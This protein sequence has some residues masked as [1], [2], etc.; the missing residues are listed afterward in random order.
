MGSISGVCAGSKRVVV[1]RIAR[2]VA[3]TLCAAI[4]LANFALA[5]SDGLVIAMPNWPSGQA[6]ANILK[7]AIAEKFGLAAEIRELGA[8]NAFAG[9]EAGT[10]DIYPEVWRPNLDSIV[11]K[12]VSQKKL[13]ILGHHRVDAWQGLCATPAAAK[14][15][16]AISDLGDPVKTAPLDTDGDGK[17]ELWIGAATWLSAGIE[18]VRANSYGYAANLTLVEAEEQVA[19]A[20]VDAAVATERPMVFA[21]YSPH[22]VFDL[23]A[24]TRLAEPP[25]DPGHWA[26]VPADDPLWISKSKAAVAWPTAYFNLAYASS[27]AKQRPEIA[28]FLENV[29][30]SPEEV[31]QMSYALEV[32]RQSASDFAEAWVKTNQ[33][34]VDGWAKP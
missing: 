3:V 10:V 8:L 13:V 11:D 31:T 23:H 26:I 1:T 32:E 29:D 4:G 9:F 34:R 19:M 22:H 33:S 27:L 20:A 12:Y 15:I 28:A 6:A 25:H 17:G 21:C 5:Q 7:V 30:F 24:I 2:C 18:R 14:A 16:K